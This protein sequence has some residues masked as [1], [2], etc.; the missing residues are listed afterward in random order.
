MKIKHSFWALALGSVITFTSCN[1]DESNTSE[2]QLKS[3]TSLSYF[4]TSHNSKLDYVGNNTSDLENSTPSER[5]ETADGYIDPVFGDLNATTLSQ[6]NTGIVYTDG[7]YSDLLNAGNTLSS[8]SYIDDSFSSYYNNLGQLFQD[9]LDSIDIQ[10]DYTPQ[11]FST[12]VDLIINEIEASHNVSL[13]ESNWSGSEAA[14]AIITL[15]IAK[16]SY[17]YWHDASVT[18]S[19]NPWASHMDIHAKVQAGFWDKLWL[20]VRKAATDV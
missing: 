16:A 11:D 12:K 6:S 18:N 19:T 20:G 9:V 1:K 3:T 8:D 17:S 4:G 2:T 13:N 14:K 10:I 15:E 7:I 5:L